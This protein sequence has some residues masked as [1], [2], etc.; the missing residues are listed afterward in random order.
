MKINKKNFNFFNNIEFFNFCV[1]LLFSFIFSKIFLK[2]I[3]NEFFKIVI[4]L[5]KIIILFLL[6]S[7]FIF[8]ISLFKFFFNIDNDNNN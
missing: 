3:V 2:N 6:L 4:I 1:K 5:F 7:L 8:Y